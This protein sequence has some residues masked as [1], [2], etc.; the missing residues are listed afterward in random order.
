MVSFKNVDI[1]YGA[2][3]VLQNFSMHIEKGEKVVL[4][5][6]SGSGKSTILNAVMGFVNIASGT[7]QVNGNILSSHT[8]HEIRQQISW[9]PQD[10]NFNVRLC[11]ELVYFPFQFEANKSLTPSESDMTNLLSALLLSPEILNKQVDEISGGQKQRLALAAVLML[12]R[13][14]ILLDEP[15][16][17]LDA[18]SA[19]AVIKILFDRKDVTVISSSHDAEWV[20][21][22]DHTIK[23]EKNN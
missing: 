16:S 13:P 20:R 21:R 2:E 14:I 18:V 1:N 9:L 11:R 4:S 3:K 7:L 8:I 5:G 15:S 10:V 12:N 6:P 19:D 17:A 22:M 23:L